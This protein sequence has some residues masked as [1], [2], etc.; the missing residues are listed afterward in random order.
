M[1]GVGAALGLQGVDRLN[2]VLARLGGI[3]TTQLLSTLG[4]VVEN[5]TKARLIDGKENPDGEAW[6]EWSP[7]Y[8][9]TRHDN[10]DLLQSSGNLID[11]LQSILGINQAEVG[12]NLDYASSHQYGNAVKGIPR[13]EFL[14]VSDGDLNDLQNVLNDW[15][16]NLIQ[17]SL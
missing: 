6:P 3:E 13:R 16:D 12:T 5:Q 15:A 8:A 17:G 7:W 2:A 4:G 11:S 10:Q 9:E 1:A 14:G